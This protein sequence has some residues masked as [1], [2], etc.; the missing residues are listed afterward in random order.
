M[1]L[2]RNDRPP[3]LPAQ[4]APFM[5]TTHTAPLLDMKMTPATGTMIDEFQ[6]MQGTTMARPQPPSPVAAEA[7]DASDATEARPDV[8]PQTP[9]V[10]RATN[11][12]E[13]H[14]NADNNADSGRTLWAYD[15]GLGNEARGQPPSS[16]PHN[17]GPPD[18]EQL[19]V[20]EQRRTWPT[21]LTNGATG[22]VGGN[23][24]YSNNDVR[25]RPHSC[26]YNSTHPEPLHHP[27][28]P[29]RRS[30]S[31]GRR[32]E[33]SNP[34]AVY[35][36]RSRPT[37]L[38]DIEQARGTRIADVQEC[39]AKRY[40]LEMEK[41]SR[42]RTNS[43]EVYRA[44]QDLRLG[45]MAGCDELSAESWRTVA[46]ADIRVCVA[47]ALILNGPLENSQ[48]E[49]CLEGAH[50]TTR[51][52]AP[53]HALCRPWNSESRAVEEIGDNSSGTVMIRRTQGARWR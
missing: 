45:N 29:E 21:P 50:Q 43:D 39:I 36:G 15:E 18:T 1:R 31:N 9:V 48:A 16:P 26:K 2:D 52:P 40:G 30:R 7:A 11:A 20:R 22:S 33:R 38:Q 13:T 53:M 46:D 12:G 4:V 37:H 25:D 27:I 8:P 49:Q 23:P 14:D 24:H 44:V 19:P 41:N 34:C 6:G 32:W 5:A 17:F 47:M 10:D 51:E 3:Q 42:M 28:A 35:A